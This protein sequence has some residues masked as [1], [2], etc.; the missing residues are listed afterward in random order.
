M[1]MFVWR[2]LTM[3]DFITKPP[4]IHGCFA[5]SSI[6]AHCIRFKLVPAT[7]LVCDNEK[8]ALVFCCSLLMA[9]PSIVIFLFQTFRVPVNGFPCSFAQSLESGDKS[10]PASLF[11]RTVGQIGEGDLVQ[12][13]NWQLDT[14][15][16]FE[17]SLTHTFLLLSLFVPGCFDTNKEGTTIA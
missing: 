9:C 14:V 10:R 16:C 2:A 3:I 6:I 11:G 15:Y 13:V 5:S 8:A 1:G 7:F 4:L 17:V 12:P